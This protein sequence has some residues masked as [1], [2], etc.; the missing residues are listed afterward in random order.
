MNRKHSKSDAEALRQ[1]CLARLAEN[2]AAMRDPMSASARALAVDLMQRRDKGEIDDAALMALVKH[3][4]DAALTARAGRL[5]A[6][7]PSGDWASVVNAALA[8]LAG[9][10]LA[11]VKAALEPG[12]LGVVFAAHPT[13]A[14]APAMRAN[15]PSR[16]AAPGLSTNFE[17]SRSSTASASAD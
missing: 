7:K 10:P 13:V 1:W 9:A 4:A 15:S 3:V 12:R 5:A 2:S 17:S 11:E 16:F 8:Q 6:S 14:L